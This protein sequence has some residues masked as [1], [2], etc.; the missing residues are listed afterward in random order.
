M[1]TTSRQMP[2]YAR[3]IIGSL[4]DYGVGLDK[5][6][7]EIGTNDGALLD[8][9]VNEGYTNILGVEPSLI[10][11]DICKAK[12]HLVENV[13]LNQA[14]ANK[15]LKKYGPAS[16]VICR[17]TIEHVPNPY[18]FLSS[19]SA[20]LLDDGLL[21]LETPNSYSIIAEL[22]GHELWDEHSYSFTDNNLAY[23]IQKLGFTLVNKET[24]F[25]QG[26][27]NILLWCR[28]TNGNYKDIIPYQ[29]NPNDINYCKSFIQRWYVYCEKLLDAS[30]LWPRPIVCIGASHPQMNFLHYTGLSPLIDILVDDDPLKIGRYA[31]LSQPTQIVS[32]NQLK[33]SGSLL[34]GTILRT[35][36]GYSE[37][38]D[39]I[40]NFFKEN[41]L[42]INVYDDFL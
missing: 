11:A 7:I 14:E 33:S 30:R 8:V 34:P 17:H 9:A 24:G 15:I 6:L 28:L 4:K 12:N 16:A 38:M 3:Q 1:R 31:P 41:A 32:T 42:I 37:W 26:A 13:H 10:C 20:L 2:H 25:H 5:L 39:K 29:D 40:C 36:F 27:K 21:I 19:I 23:L 18:D 22:Q 35:A